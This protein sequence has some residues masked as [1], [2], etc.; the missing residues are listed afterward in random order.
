MF[1]DY[2]IGYLESYK[3]PKLTRALGSLSSD[4][5]CTAIHKQNCLIAEAESQSLKSE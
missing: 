3:K 1:L 5:S 2:A 4:Y